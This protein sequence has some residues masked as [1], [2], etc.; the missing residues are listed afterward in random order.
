MGK[1]NKSKNAN[2]MNK[3]QPAV[4]IKTS[5]ECEQCGNQCLRGKNYIQ[6]MKAGG[7]VGNGVP[8]YNK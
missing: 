5:F 6:R 1:P 2:A 4:T 3:K 7:V 8:C